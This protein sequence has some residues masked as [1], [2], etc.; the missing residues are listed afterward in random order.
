MSHSSHLR[1][2][3]NLLPS[4]NSLPHIVQHLLK[5]KNPGMITIFDLPFLTIA[6]HPL[7][8]A[9]A[10]NTHPTGILTIVRTT[11]HV[12]GGAY[13]HQLHRFEGGVCFI[14]LILM[15]P[16]NKRQ[17][18]TYTV[19]SAVSPLKRHF[20]RPAE[21]IIVCEGAGVPYYLQSPLCRDCKTIKGRSS[22][23]PG[24]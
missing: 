11:R 1:G 7:G 2:Q 23:L 6:L 5:V 19:H 17:G 18:G 9:L 24:V 21:L 22:P 16:L 14:G 8:L 4:N 12:S 15:S 3:I 10:H 13:L 20:L